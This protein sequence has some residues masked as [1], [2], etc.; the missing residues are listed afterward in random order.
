MA[1]IEFSTIG[2]P[3]EKI[4]AAL[5]RFEAETG[6]TVQLHVLQWEYAWSELL[7][8]A[9]HGHGPDVSHVGSTWVSSLVKMDAL[10]PFTSKEVRE[11]GGA[12]AFLNPCWS[13]VV[14]PEDE[15]AWALPWTSYIFL[16]L[17][18]R[19]LL[20]RAGVDEATAFS[21]ARSLDETCQKLQAAR[22]LL[23][24]VVPTGRPHVDTIHMVASWVWGAGGDFVAEDGQ[25][26]LFTHAKAHAGLMAYYEL[27]RYIPRLARNLTPDQILALFRDGEAAVTICGIEEPY[28]IMSTE[29]AVPVV[30]D[31]LGIVAIP[32]QPWVGGDHLVIW[33]HAAY[34]PAREQAAVALVQ[35][36]TSQEVQ[37]A[38]FQTVD[39]A[40]PTRLDALPDMPFPESEAT[41]QVTRSLLEGRS[42][43]PVALWGRVE[44]QLSSAL[45]HIWL[46][47][48]DGTPVEKAIKHQIGAVARRLE[49]ALVE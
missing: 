35:Y 6:H 15:T 19:D 25:K 12:K 46:E 28:T 34:D 13:S 3:N 30:R 24:W 22:V 8:Y 16:L 18:R 32:G 7:S 20:A 2:Q 29:E 10:R 27:N 37:R 40:G 14:L 49:T 41:R 1:Q 47:I 36:L 21:T 17:Y 39:F 11:V 43:P 23:P 45:N 5:H 26:L 33:R 31:N 9:L 4:T 44:T 48:F 38:S 42:Y